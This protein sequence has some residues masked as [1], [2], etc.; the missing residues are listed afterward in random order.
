[1]SRFPTL[2]AAVGLSHAADQMAL[3]AL[4]LCAVLALGAGPGLTGALVAAQGAAWLL[5]SLPAGV[6]VD[7]GSKRG[8]IV[9]A[10]V[11]AALACA[12]AAFAAW[13]GVGPL[14]GLASF[15]GAGGTV[16][17]AL[18]ALALV[19][20]LVP[21]RELPK[22]NARLELARAGAALAAPV[23]VG[24]LAAR[25]DP[26][27][28]FVVA[29]VAAALAAI[30]A[31]R[32]PEGAE[33][34][35]PNRPPLARAIREGADFALR[36]PLLRGIVLCAVFWNFAFFALLAVAVPFALERIGL[37]A[38]RT[39]LMQGGYGVGLIL[40][41]LVAPGLLAR[42]A[43]RTVLIAGP[44]LS[45]LAACLLWAAPR[46]GGFG[47]GLAAY[48]LISGSSARRASASS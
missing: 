35:A 40:G 16:V 39:G 12:V 6:V 19:P 15:V 27:L 33:P 11:A 21:A 36:H 5:V 42:V 26:A 14:L 4:P 23:L 9:G 13:Q 45:T 25:A 7:R 10:Q 22:A 28:G 38:A 43:P 2:F 44:A 24:F 34:A 17:L 29:A 47:A 37:D 46:G 1:M 41:A 48:F 30:V 8:L 20:N 31:A 32:L 18:A 3:A